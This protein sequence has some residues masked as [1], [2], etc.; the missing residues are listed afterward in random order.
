[1]FLFLIR[2]MKTY[3]SLVTVVI[4]LYFVSIQ[5]SSESV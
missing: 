5:V 2:C 4:P 3:V 1:M